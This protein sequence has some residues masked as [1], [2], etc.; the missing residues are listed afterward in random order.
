MKI[1]DVVRQ[2]GRLIEMKGRDFPTNLW[3]FGVVIEI[4]EDRGWP[5][6]Y[7]KWNKWLGRGVT[8]LWSNGRIKRMAENA[9][10]VVDEKR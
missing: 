8:V 9:L 5:A 3:R 6:K 10:E 1:G 4:H 2:N 7:E